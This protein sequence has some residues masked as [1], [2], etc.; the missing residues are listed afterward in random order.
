MDAAQSRRALPVTLALAVTLDVLLWAVDADD[1]AGLPA[2]YWIMA[3]L[4]LVVDARP[5]V[6]ATRRASSIVLPS[7]CFTFAIVLAWGLIPALAVQVAAITVAGARM[8]RP[9]RR[10]VHLMG[11]HAVALAGA[12]IVAVVAGLGASAATG[13]EVGFR[14]G[15][16]DAL[17]TV[18][19]AVAWMAA[20][21][22]VAALVAYLL[23]P[24]RAPRPR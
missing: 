6:V 14:P 3:A 13:L 21:Y 24:R 18:G 16:D 2:A 9:V 19:A 5:Y 11:Q 15:W 1:F 12:A 20:R 22:G 8:R 7:I 10:T 23:S 17:F 4:A